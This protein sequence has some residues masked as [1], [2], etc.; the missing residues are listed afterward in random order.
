MAR[1]KL[2]AAQR[3]AQLIEVG[4]RVFA[5]RGFEATTVE[6]V[7]ARA[8]VSKPIVYQH[9]GG[10]EGLYAVVVDREMA[11]IV[12]AITAAISKGSPRHRTEQAV[13]AFLGYAASNPEGFRVLAH[14]APASEAG[15]MSSVM[16]E[17]AERVGEVFALNFKAAGYD[18]KT[19]PIYA[20]ALVGMV[21]AVANWW[22]D[23]RK[24]KI[25]VVASHIAALAWMGL[26]HLP[27][28]PERLSRKK[29]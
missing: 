17:V 18:P 21:S 25:E 23:A 1:K 4:R 6:E 20:H 19:A 29:T 14:D 22:V 9:F 26:R 13:L 3:R 11:Q 16:S 12:A 27:K 24:P 8:K 15:G 5:D 28:K 2:S 7:A 10:K